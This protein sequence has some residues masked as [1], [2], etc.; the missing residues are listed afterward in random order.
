MET[1]PQAKATAQYDEY[2]Y[3]NLDQVLWKIEEKI[4]RWWKLE[5]GDRKSRKILEVVH[6]S[7]P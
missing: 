2:S 6:L 7:L 4:N 1:K 5:G 3:R